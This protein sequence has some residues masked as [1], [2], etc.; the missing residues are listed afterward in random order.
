MTTFAAMLASSSEQVRDG[1]LVVAA[2]IAFAAGAN[3]RLDQLVLLFF[4]GCGVSRLARYNVTAE[5]L[6]A[7]TGKVEYFKM[8][9]KYGAPY[10]VW[11]DKKGNIWTSDQEYGA[12]V[13]F[14]EATKKWTYFPYP[15]FEGHAPKMDTDQDN[16][17]WMSMGRPSALTG[18]NE[19]GNQMRSNSTASR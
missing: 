19:A 18:F 16:T 13:K 11:P 8:P 15:V 10:E 12:L 3:T 14:E 4:V 9:L 17:L 6:A 7:P 5:S 2:P 1:S